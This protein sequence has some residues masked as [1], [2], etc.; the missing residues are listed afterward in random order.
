M[1]A[2]DSYSAVVLEHIPG[3]SLAEYIAEH[4]R[5]SVYFSERFFAQIIS[6]VEY[7]HRNCM[8]HS[9]LSCPKVLLGSNQNAVLTRFSNLKTFD[10]QHMA[11]FMRSQFTL[12]IPRDPYYYAPEASH[13]FYEGRQADVWNC[14]V[15][16]VS[17]QKA[18]YWLLR[19]WSTSCLLVTCL[20]PGGITILHG[21]DTRLQL[22]NIPSTSL[23]F[24]EYFIPH[25]KD[26]GRRMLVEQ[27]TGRAELFE[28]ACHCWLS[29]Y[30]DIIKSSIIVER[31]PVPY[32]ITILRTSSSTVEEWHGRYAT[33]LRHRWIRS[34]PLGI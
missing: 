33:P 18:W 17:D 20:F 22:Y 29:D 31:A 7:V 32:C 25:A 4:T 24:P 26:L 11:R 6:A 34:Q 28:V 23:T 9:T 1:F 30:F 3:G 21:Y 13:R 27:F 12:E 19:I 5:L 14:G 15:I 10:T 16:L 2:T 8:A